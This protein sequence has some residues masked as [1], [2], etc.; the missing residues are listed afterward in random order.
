M[1]SNDSIPGM[2]SNAGYLFIVSSDNLLRCI[3]MA[4][5]K[6][7]SMIGSGNVG[8]TAGQ[9]IAENDLSEE[10][11][12]I[13]VVEGLPQ[14]RAL[15][16]L[17]S[18]PIEG[19]TTSI[20]GSNDYSSISQSDLIVVTAGLARKPGMTRSDLLD[21]NA[22]ILSDVSQN[23]RK[24]APEAVVIVVT[25]PMDVMTYLVYK[26]TGFQ[27]NRVVGMA[28]VL[29][30]ARFRTFVGMELGIHSSQ[31]TGFV[32]GGH[33]PSMVPVISS[34]AAG[35]IPLT[36][37]ISK[38]RLES[39]IQ[40]TRMGGDE[41]VNLLKTGSAFYAPASSIYEMARSIALDQKK[42]L[43]CSAYLDGEFGIRDVYTGVPV[44][45]GRKG[46]ERIVELKLTEEEAKALQGS[47]DA[48]KKDIE[49]L[50][51]HGYI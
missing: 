7:I 13:D 37:L 27:K 22:S 29:D 5:L 18:S 47:A 26:K 48:V 38:E 2:E 31:V 15:D 21:K 25:N 17:E 46:V 39:I 6:K 35:G 24:Y 33:G 12:F 8:S 28:G 10:L 4:A 45:L 41:I 9:K 19:F 42:I 44:V 1:I 51:E 43:P 11:V 40:R 49:L 34:A 20:T 30:T 23:I 32:I 3:K 16:M 50:R 14:G 36:Q